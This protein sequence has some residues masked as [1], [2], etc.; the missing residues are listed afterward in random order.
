M[1]PRKNVLSPLLELME[2][3]ALPKEDYA[4]FVRDMLKRFD[5][6]FADCFPEDEVFLLLKDIRGKVDNILLKTNDACGKISSCKAA[7]SENEGKSQT[8]DKKT[9]GSRKDVAVSVYPKGYSKN[10]KKT[11]TPEKEKYRCKRC[12]ARGRKIVR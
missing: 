11:R 7:G 10:G 6:S 8:E 2:K 3:M 12:A 4:D 1:E 9:S 5:L